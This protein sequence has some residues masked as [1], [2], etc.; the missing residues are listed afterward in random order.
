MKKKLSKI[1]NHLSGRKREGM[2]TRLILAIAL[3]LIA[4][5]VDAYMIYTN[6]DYLP[7]QIG[8]TYDWDSVATLSEHKSVFWH[9][10]LYRFIGLVAF[11][12]VGWIIYAINKSSLIRLRIFT[13]LTETVNLI[14]L[15][16]VGVSLIMLAIS[17]GDD[18]QKVSDYWETVVLY[19]WFIILLVE[20]IFDIR[21][22]KKEKKQIKV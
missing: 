7:T 21:F 9:Y 18:T 1:G 3:A 5:L 19:I 17:M 15:T 4:M 11:V 6:Y 14:I 8:T 22:L 10:E 20:F 12:A 13:F 2:W 16:C